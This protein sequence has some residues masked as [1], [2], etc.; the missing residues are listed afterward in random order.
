MKKRRVVFII[1]L[2][3]GGVFTLVFIN[4]CSTINLNLSQ[5]SFADI[6]DLSKP[7]KA[8]GFE[9]FRVTNS[10]WN[11]IR[12]NPKEDFYLIA[13]SKKI[14]KLDSKG[15]VVYQ[16]DMNEFDPNHLPDNMDYNQPTSFVVSWYGIYD[17]SKEK[18]AVEKFSKSINTEGNMDKDAWQQEFEKLYQSSDIAFWG[19]RKGVKSGKLYPL[20]FRQN[21]QWIVFYTNEFT[22]VYHMQ[23]NPEI[24][25]NDRIIPE[26]YER[27]YLLKDIQR[28][29]AYSDFL[30][31]DNQYDFS[32]EPEGKLKFSKRASIKTL[33]F[34]KEDVED[35]PYTII[36]AQ[37]SG[38]AVNELSFENSSIKFKTKALKGAGLN[39]GP[40]ETDFFIFEVPDEFKKAN[41]LLFFYYKYSTNWNANNT[42][43]VYVLRKTN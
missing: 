6:P 5:P 23:K 19:F 7:L 38:T 35:A 16:L 18:P 28:N 20:Y 8:K 1:I 9:L 21:G 17:L 10:T 3:L 42:E 36:P 30:S 12:Y 25:I 40:V 2:L 11:E 39:F 37:F 4:R 31:S 33:F 34:R 41:S 29:N 43:G 15:S 22:S 14:T 32:N 27:L 13:E 26:K 24:H